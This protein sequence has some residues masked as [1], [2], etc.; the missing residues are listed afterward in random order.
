RAEQVGGPAE[1]LQRQF[2]EKILAG[3]PLLHLSSD[4]RLVGAR[5][6]K[7]MLEN[8]RVRGQARQRPLVDV[9]FGGS[10]REQAAGDVV[11][12]KALPQIVKRLRCF[13]GSAPGLEL[14]PRETKRTLRFA[15]F[16]FVTPVAYYAGTGREG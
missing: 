9:A 4:R 5:I 13:H 10:A 8:C 7:G 16:C 14:T 11:E 1:I 2:E 6:A 3:L 12:P 15:R